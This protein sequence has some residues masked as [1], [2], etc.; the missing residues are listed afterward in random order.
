M[1]VI[2]RRLFLLVSAILS[3]GLSV[4]AQQSTEPCGMRIEYGNRNQVEPARL[5]V[6]L[7]SGLVISEVGRDATR[8]EVGPVSGACLGLFTEQDHRLVATIMADQQGYFE[9]SSVPSGQYRLVVQAKPLCLANVR[10][11]VRRRSISATSK[12]KLIIHMR[13]AGIDDCSYGEFK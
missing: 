8:R 13:A 7:V 1:N 4:C 5:S 9:F 3:L 12:H 10:L 11:R 2:I 6:G